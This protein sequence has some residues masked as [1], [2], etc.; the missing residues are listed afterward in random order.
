[1]TNTDPSGNTNLTPQQTSTFK[2]LPTSASMHVFSGSDLG[3]TAREYIS[4][5]EDVMKN[6][7]INDKGDQISFVRS[8]LQ[9][10]SRA[11]HMM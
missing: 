3:Y 11:S 6:S 9:L 5:C 1:M 8:C 4:L 2:L 7:D 10:G